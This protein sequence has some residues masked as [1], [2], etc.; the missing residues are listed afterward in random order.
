MFSTGNRR[1][2]PKPTVEA[3]SSAGEGLNKLNLDLEIRKKFQQPL[4]IESGEFPTRETIEQRLKPL[5]FESHLTAGHDPDAANLVSVAAET[6]IREMLSTTFTSTRANG[7]GDG[8][9]AGFGCGTGWIQT[10]RYR[11]QLRQEEE[12]WAAGEVTRDKF[13]LLPVEAKAAQ[14]RSPLSMAEIR[15]AL[16]VAPSGVQNFP[17]VTTDIFNGYREGELEHYDEYTIFDGDSNQFN[18]GPRTAQPPNGVEAVTVANGGD[19]MD[20]EEPIP[21]EGGG[22]AD[23]V[24]FQGAL[25]EILAI[26]S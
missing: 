9:P 8:G 26:R 22:R 11:K 14:E 6:F 5:C 13:G 17:A 12:A 1:K 3:S 21:W 16:E 24:N 7:P 19:A 25:D 10:R 15:L 20:L 4:S 18:A 2:V 23:L